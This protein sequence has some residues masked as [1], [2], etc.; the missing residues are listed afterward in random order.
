MAPKT[1]R[2]E[3]LVSCTGIAGVQLL[4]DSGCGL[5]VRTVE[6][7]P[8]RVER[9]ADDITGGGLQLQFYIAFQQTLRDGAVKDLIGAVGDVYNAQ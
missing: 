8:R 4:P 1:R 5:R 3:P 2:Q 7:F 9:V 6:T